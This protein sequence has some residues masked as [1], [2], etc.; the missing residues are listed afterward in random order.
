MNPTVAIILVN[1]NGLMFTKQCLNSLRT[2][3]YR[4]VQVIVVDNASSDGSAEIL[5]KE[6]PEVVI[7]HA[8]SNLGFAGGNNL[9]FQYAFQ[10]GFSYIMMLNNDTIVEPDFMDHLIHYMETHPETGAIQPRIHFEHDRSLIWNGG[11]RHAVWPGFL[12]AQDAGRKPGKKSLQLKKVDWITG[13]AF[14]IRTD[15][16][17]KTGLLAEN[18]FMYS[19]D[20]DLSMRIKAHGY[21]LIYHPQSVIYHIAGMSNKTTTKGKEGYVNPMVHY[22][23]QRNRLWILKKYTPIY[24]LPTVIICNFFYISLI[25][26]YFALRGRFN[27]LK[28]VIKAVK[29][30]LTGTVQ[31]QS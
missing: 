24:A 14:L 7:I 3:Q 27:K 5:K 2:L 26:G 9:G 16:L 18:L 29:D 25:I 13:C 20:V 31:Y 30:G 17:Q 4:S 12:Y 10:H 22:Y 8:G 19:E 23:N 15:V 21:S 6:Y 11:S 28:A 1:W